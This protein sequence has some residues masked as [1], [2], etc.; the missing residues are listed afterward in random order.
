MDPEDIDALVDAEI[1][2]L[3][4]VNGDPGSVIVPIV[5]PDLTAS[6]MQMLEYMEKKKEQATGYSGD[7]HSM[8]PNASTDTAS[9]LAQ[10]AESSRPAVDKCPR[11]PT[12]VN[13]P[14]QQQLAGI[15][16]EFG[17]TQPCGEFGQRTGTESLLVL[18][19]TH[20]SFASAETGR[21]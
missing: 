18:L 1:G 8:A 12:I 4:G 20:R 6:G 21:N 13:H 15:T 17:G 3:I 10:L 14:A 9:G 7:A 5:T 11:A 2:G 19:A 16:L